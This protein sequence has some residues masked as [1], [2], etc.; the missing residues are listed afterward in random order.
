MQQIP[1]ELGEESTSRRNRFQWLLDLAEVVDSFRIFP[2]IFIAVYIYMFYKT[3][4]WFMMIPEP[5][6][7]QAGLISVITGI[8][9][10]WF[11]LYVN[12]GGKKG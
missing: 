10:A 12:S 1:L 11:G 2:R 4:D 3:I 7:Q 8:G 9:A 5:N 6:N